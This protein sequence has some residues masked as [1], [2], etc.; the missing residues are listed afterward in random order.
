MNIHDPDLDDPDVGDPEKR[1]KLSLELQKLASKVVGKKKPWGLAG[2]RQHELI[3]E[4]VEKTEF[5]IKTKLD[6]TIIAHDLWELTKKLGLPRADE[7]GE[8]ITETLLAKPDLK[9]E[10]A[11][12]VEAALVAAG[13]PRKRAHSMLANFRSK[14]KSPVDE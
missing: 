4:A 1:R 11:T 12:L 10:A 14:R 7:A 6:P 2:K 3:R 8:K 13:I 9:G 5:W